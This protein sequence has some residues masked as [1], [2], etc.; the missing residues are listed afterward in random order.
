MLTNRPKNLNLFTLRFPL[1]AVVSI[2]HRLT[3]V[4][5]FLTIPALA[6]LFNLSLSSASAF[7]Q[8]QQ[9]FMQ[10][11]GKCLLWLALSF[12]FYHALAGIRHMIMDAG[13]GKTWRQSQFSAILTL[14]TAIVSALGIGVWLC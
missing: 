10:G 14:S 3:G 2:L 8:I 12:M 13:Y 5:L 9:F 4:L 6:L 7:R 1:S 11:Y